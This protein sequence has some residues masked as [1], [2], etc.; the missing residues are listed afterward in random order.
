MDPQQLNVRRVDRKV[1]AGL[2][3]GEGWQYSAAAVA[4]DAELGRAAAAIATGSAMSASDR[5]EAWSNAS[6]PSALTLS[7]TVRAARAKGAVTEM[8]DGPK[9]LGGGGVPTAARA[10]SWCW[11]QG[12]MH[13]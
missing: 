9:R 12:R 7:T 4:L 2:H 6:T 11:V 10:G 1:D 8:T 3:G 5:A 13:W